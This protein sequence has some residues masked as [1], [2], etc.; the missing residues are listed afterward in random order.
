MVEL[1]NYNRLIISRQVDF[2]VYL[3]DEEETQEILMPSRYLPQQY[4]IGD[5][6]DAFVY[7]DSEDRWIATT[8]TPIAK[9][10][11]F[12]LLEVKQVTRYGAFL[13]WGV[14]KDLF[15]P[16]KEQKKKMEVGN[17]YVVYIYVD[18]ETQRIAAS[19]KIDRYVSKEP[20]AYKRGDK[21]DLLIY[22]YTPFGYKA[23]VDNRYTGIIYDDEV[24]KPLKIGD[25]IA[26]YIK[27]VR[28]DD[29]LDLTVE[30]EGYGKVEELASQ[31]L[32]KLKQNGRIPLNDHSPA[33]QIYA[34]CGM[35]KKTFKKVIGNLYKQR[36]ITIDE[37]GIELIAHK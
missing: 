31:L 20:T 21:V 24:F 35:S 10:G 30:K 28:E 36:I 23:V 3:K 16:F 6:I 12:A 15:V 5:T 27:H 4:E 25:R 32:E 34:L 14:M 9:V 33:E 13:D 37:Q 7:K 2:G 18:E 26:G 17:S 1:G 22:Q 8:E 11:D 19:T 29:K